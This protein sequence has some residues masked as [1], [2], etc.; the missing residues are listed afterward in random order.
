MADLVCVK[1]AI[2]HAA[3]TTTTTAAAAA[4]SALQEHAAEDSGGG[5]TALFSQQGRVVSGDEMRQ[6][7]GKSVGVGDVSD[8]VLLVDPVPAS[9]LARR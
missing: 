4:D 5:H 3:A 9:L 2:L 7:G 6:A 8:W 1:S